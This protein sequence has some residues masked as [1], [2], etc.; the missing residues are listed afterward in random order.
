[1]HYFPHGNVCI[2]LGHCQVSGLSTSVI[3]EMQHSTSRMSTIALSL[4]SD[5]WFELG[6]LVANST[7]SLIRQGE[8][9]L[10]FE[11]NFVDSLEFDELTELNRDCKQPSRGYN[12]VKYVLYF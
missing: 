3:L 8:A 6:V 2:S 11:V 10:Y 7:F 9:M 1:M 12:N 4:K 5:V